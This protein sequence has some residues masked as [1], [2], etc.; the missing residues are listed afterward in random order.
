MLATNTM[1]FPQMPLT[2]TREADMYRI[3]FSGRYVD[4]SSYEIKNDKV[5]INGRTWL[6]DSYLLQDV[7]WLGNRG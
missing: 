4:V 3:F 5:Y 7:E 1:N 6:C 2:L